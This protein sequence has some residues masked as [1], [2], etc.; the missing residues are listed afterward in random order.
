MPKREPTQGKE[1]DS[2][3]RFKAAQREFI[4]VAGRFDLDPAAKQHAAELR[5][6]TKSVADNIV[7]DPGL[8]R[9]AER[10]G[11]AGQVKSLAREKERGLSREK[12]FEMER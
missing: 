2:I 6:E 9:E 4:K 11:I 12:G 5:Q 10:D 8:L 7:K 3:E 1:H